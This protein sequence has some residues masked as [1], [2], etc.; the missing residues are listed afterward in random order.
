MKPEPKEGE[1]PGL[2]GLRRWRQVYAWVL[3]SFLLWV[4]LLVVLAK[5]F[6]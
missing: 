2:L 4:G 5:L 3:G 6:P 1:A